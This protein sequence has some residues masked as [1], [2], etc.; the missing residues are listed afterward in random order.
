MNTKKITT[1]EKQRKST[2][3]DNNLELQIF[4][5]FTLTSNKRTITKLHIPIKYKKTVNPIKNKRKTT[6][7]AHI[8]KKM[9]NITKFIKIKGVK[10]NQEAALGIISVI[11][12]KRIG[13]TMAME[14]I[15]SRKKG[16]IEN[17]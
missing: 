7:M 1:K 11:N 2:K 13:K 8:D 14:V 9:S 10:E 17:S 15:N 16:I 12:S 4:S 3:T 5:N 6:I